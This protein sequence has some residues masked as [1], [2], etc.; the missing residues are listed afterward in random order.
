MQNQFVECPDYDYATWKMIATTGTPDVRYYSS[1]GG[2]T[3][4]ENGR[5]VAR[6]FQEI[7]NGREGIYFFD[8]RD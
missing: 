8:T 7:T 6:E 1:A 2:T 4:K 3:F 5:G